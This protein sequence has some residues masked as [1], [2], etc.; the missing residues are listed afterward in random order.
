M[1]PH[2]RWTDRGQ[3]TQEHALTVHAATAAICDI[4]NISTI[5]RGADAKRLIK[6]ILGPVSR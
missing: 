3:R 6:R 2:V 1:R 5:K 4:D